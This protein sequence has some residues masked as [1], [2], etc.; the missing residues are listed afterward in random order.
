MVAEL[1]LNDL[2]LGLAVRMATVVPELCV[3]CWT[4]GCLC[5]TAN[6]VYQSTCPSYYP[7]TF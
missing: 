5:V 1:K 4:I 3:V 7:V 2:A 6:V